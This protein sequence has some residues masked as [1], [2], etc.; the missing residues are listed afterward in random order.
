MISEDPVKQRAARIAVSLASVPLESEK[1]FPAFARRD[2]GDLLRE[3]RL[4]FGRKYSGDVLQFIHLRMHRSIHPFIAVADADRQ[5]SAEKI[6][7][8]V[9]FGIPDELILGP[10][11]HQRLA[12]V[13]EHR[14]KE[15]FL[16]RQN[17]FFFGHTD[18]KSV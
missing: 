4:R 17:D 9:A 2:V 12:V 13:M 18:S 16:I 6:Q 14:R 15:V 3:R 7:V 11:Q 1:R 10:R 8:L 5:D